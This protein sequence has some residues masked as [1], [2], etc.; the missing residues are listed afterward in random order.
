MEQIHRQG[1]DAQS[2]NGYQKVFGIFGANLGVGALEG[3]PTVEHIVG[4][5]GEY[6]SQDVAEVFVEL[7]DFLEKPSDTEVDKYAGK[8]HNA[9]LQE[10]Q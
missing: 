5:S 9:E 1:V 7:T 4:S 2:H 3:P 6:E 10:F 8:P